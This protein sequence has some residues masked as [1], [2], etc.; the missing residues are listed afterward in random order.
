M[1]KPP[2]VSVGIRIVFQA[3]FLGEKNGV[4]ADCESPTPDLATF[5]WPSLTTIAQVAF[6][7]T[8]ALAATSF[9]LIVRGSEAGPALRTDVRADTLDKPAVWSFQSANPHHFLSRQEHLLCPRQ[10]FGWPELRHTT[11][12]C[13]AV[14]ALLRSAAS[15]AVRIVWAAALLAA[16]PGRVPFL[17]L[18]T[19]KQRPPPISVVN[20][21]QL[22]DSC[23]S[24]LR[25]FLAPC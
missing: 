17:P 16:R 4:V 7:Q 9:D 12:Q 11:C 1:N 6:A 18:R 20:S 15:L 24:C 23:A 8:K 21:S 13:Q 5:P 22:L 19:A 2:G 14:Q 3:E 10:R 25:P